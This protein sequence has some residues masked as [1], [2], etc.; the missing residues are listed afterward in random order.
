M[1]QALFRTLAMNSPQEPCSAG[2]LS[3]TVEPGRAVAGTED[4]RNKVDAVSID[5]VE[6]DLGETWQTRSSNLTGET[7]VEFWVIRDQRKFLS[8][9]CT[10]SIPQCWGNGI[11]MQNG[12]AHIRWKS[13]MKTTLSHLPVATFPRRQSRSL[14]YRAIPFVCVVLR[15]SLRQA[16][17]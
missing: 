10:K 16:I 12:I 13:G 17:R 15:R 4:Q 3:N 7:S 14:G 1:G 9:G 6:D 11:E 5:R 2:F 8:H